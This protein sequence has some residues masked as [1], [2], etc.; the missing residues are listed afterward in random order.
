MS[1]AYFTNPV[2]TEIYA[3]CGLDAPT[4]CK[5]APNTGEWRPRELDR[6]LVSHGRIRRGRHRRVTIPNQI[7]T[8][9]RPC[10][11]SWRRVLPLPPS[12]ENGELPFAKMSYSSPAIFVIT[13]K[14]DC[15]G[16]LSRREQPPL[17]VRGGVQ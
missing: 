5:M 9:K 7:V 16:F 11:D 1:N 10:L 3:P 2:I 6:V 4:G 14:T 8:A 13:P 17:V 15:A 12:R